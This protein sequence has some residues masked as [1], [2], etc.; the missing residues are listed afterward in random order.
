MDMT[1]IETLLGLASTAVGVTGKAAS[2]A[3]AIRKLFS[4]DNGASDNSEAIKLVNAL[5]SE[6][7][8]ANVMNV[9]LSEALKELSQEL[10]REDQFEKDKGRYELVETSQGAMVYKLRKDMAEGEPEHYVCPACLKKDRL[11][12]YI[13]GTG[14]YKRCQV[15]HDH[16]Y[17]FGNTPIRVNRQPGGWT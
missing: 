1:T 2:T 8:T 17:K 15:N 10:R 9:Q 13:Q 6:L 7:T 14:D 3:D 11:I 12:I 16:L 5:A 4:S